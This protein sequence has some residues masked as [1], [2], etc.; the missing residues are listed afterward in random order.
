ML[1]VTYEVRKKDGGQGIWVKKNDRRQDK[2]NGEKMLGANSVS[3][4]IE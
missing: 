1:E 2:E 3:F 4:E